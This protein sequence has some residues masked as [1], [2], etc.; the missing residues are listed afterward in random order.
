MN[1]RPGLVPLHLLFLGLP[2]PEVAAWHDN[3]AGVG[4]ATCQPAA[5]PSAHDVLLSRHDRHRTQ[6]RSNRT[7]DAFG[8][9]Q[10]TRPQQTLPDQGSAAIPTAD[11]GDAPP[12]PR[13]GPEACGKNF[14]STSP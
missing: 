3:G 5:V 8:R 12:P 6:S 10:W 7:N 4:D 2:W 1:D 9:S 13:M 11:A 14:R